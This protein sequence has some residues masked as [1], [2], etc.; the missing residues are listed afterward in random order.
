MTLTVTHPF[1]SGKSDTADT[2]LVQPSNWNASHTLSGTLPVTNGGTGVSSSTGSGSVVLSASPALTGTPT[3]DTALLV[4]GTSATNVPNYA[5]TATSPSLQLASA[6]Y[7]AATLQSYVAGS[8]APSVTFAHSRSGTVG[9]QSVLSSGDGLGYAVFAGSDG[10]AFIRG[11][12]VAAAV[13][14]TPG[15]SAMPGRLVFSTTRGGK[16]TITTIARVSNVVTVTASATIAGYIAVG[17]TVVI[18]GVTDTGFNGSFTVTTVPSLTTFTFDQTAADA[19]DATG[20]ATV[21]GTAPVERM[22]IDNRG[23]VGIGTTSLTGYMLR[24]V[25]NSTGAASTQ[26]IYVAPTVMQ[27]VSSGCFVYR[28]AP[29][30]QAAS[31][32]LPTIYH[33]SASQGTIGANSAVTSQTG[34]NVEATLIGATT[35]YGFRVSDSAAVT[36]GK[37]HYAF[38]SANNTATGGGTT[39]QFYAAGTA[40]NVFKG[41]TTLGGT[42]GDNVVVGAGAVAT[43][44]TAGFLWITSCAG[45]PSGAP[46]APYTNAAALVVDTTNSKLYVRVGTSWKSTTLA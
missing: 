20:T 32:T 15:T 18:A 24:I 10:T 25:G 17:D 21:Q 40:D 43:N 19:S 1:V 23:S 2:S 4:G 28:S 3:I 42:T 37:S 6:S 27:D 11:A 30:T 45:A 34:F 12:H 16:F 5:G 14:A 31:F 13:D 22:R 41:K 46:T 33:F 44:A 29:A 38:Y 36:T 35:N 8:G 39:Y 9:T 26:G 7:L